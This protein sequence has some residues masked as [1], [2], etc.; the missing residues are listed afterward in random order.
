MSL[1]T[2]PVGEAAQASSDGDQTPDK[3][4]KKN[5]CFNCRKKVGL[6]GKNQG[7]SFLFVKEGCAAVFKTLQN[8]ALLLSCL[9]SC[10]VERINK[11]SSFSI[12]AQIFTLFCLVLFPFLSHIQR[13]PCMQMY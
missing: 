12:P 7:R 3:N 8:I 10:L 4:K 5:R 2:G 13:F 9:F 11:R 6:T 1:I